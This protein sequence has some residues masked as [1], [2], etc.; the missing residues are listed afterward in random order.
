MPG[1]PGNTALQ[2]ARELNSALRA[3]T[4]C[5]VQKPVRLIWYNEYEFVGGK[6]FRPGY[7]RLDL[8]RLPSRADVLV[9]GVGDAS[10]AMATGVVEY[11]TEE[12][13]DARYYGAGT[14][15]FTFESGPYTTLTINLLS[16]RASFETASRAFL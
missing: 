10:V 2:S 1:L 12:W 5:G 15:T 14:F 7:L 4:W 8:F 6:P 9:R 3:G 13:Y 16:G 11:R